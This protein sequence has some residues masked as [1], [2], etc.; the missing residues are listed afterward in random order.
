MSVNA[1]DIVIDA[2]RPVEFG[3]LTTFRNL[4]VLALSTAADRDAAYL[5]LDEAL[6][7]RSVHVFEVN[8]G[9]HVPELKIVNEGELPVLLLDGEELLGAKQNR[10]INLTI[11]AP[12]HQTR[13]IPVSCVESGRWHH[14]SRDFV[15]APR[16]QFAEGRAAR[17]QHVTSSLMASGSR[18]SDQQDVWNL[19]ADKSARL[20]AVSDTAAM[21]AM[22]DRYHVSLEEFVMAFTPVE[23]QVGAVFFVNGRPAGLELFDAGRTWR[24]L[25]SKLI[26]SYA[27]DALDQANDPVQSNAAADARALIQRLTSS[28]TS[29]FP[30]VGEGEDVRFDG[31]GVVGAALVASGTAIH[32]SAFSTESMGESARKKGRRPRA[33]RHRASEA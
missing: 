13:V 1:A 29:V 18:S 10:V 21:S 24:T 7:Q 17:M 12:A 28:Q 27:L 3:P 16:A 19:I 25:A 9:G 23:R 32:V 8:Q 26:R 20:G 4:S 14:V 15:A 11:L 33:G 2:I 5:T 30:A 22:F 31:T 6:A